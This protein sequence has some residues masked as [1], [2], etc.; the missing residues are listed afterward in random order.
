MLFWKEGFEGGILRC[1]CIWA[2]ALFLG[3]LYFSVFLSLEILIKRILVRKTS[4]YISRYVQ[5]FINQI[6]Q[7]DLFIFTIMSKKIKFSRTQRSSQYMI[8]CPI[9]ANIFF[10]ITFKTFYQNC[11]LNNLTNSIWNTAKLHNDIIRIVVEVWI[12]P[13]KI[14][15]R[16]RLF[17]FVKNSSQTTCVLDWYILKLMVLPLGKL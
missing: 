1:G 17:Y 14:L 10:W 12:L 7:N 13:A 2:R 5:T 11:C 4:V 16:C 9:I 3:N 6:N 15:I 8:K